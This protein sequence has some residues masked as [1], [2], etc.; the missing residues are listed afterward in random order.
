VRGS[1]QPGVSRET[2]AVFMEPNW[3]E[4][5]RIPEGRDISQ[6]QSQSATENLPKGVPALATRYHPSQTFGDFTAA[7]LA[8]YY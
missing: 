4:P 7:T 6:T 2:F 5:M 3:Y 1:K 8:A